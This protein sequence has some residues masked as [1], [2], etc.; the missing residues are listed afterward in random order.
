VPRIGVVHPRVEIDLSAGD[1]PE[2]LQRRL[3]LDQIR[4][5]DVH[6]L[7][8]VITVHEEDVADAEVGIDLREA[9]EPGIPPPVPVM[10]A[11]RGLLDGDPEPERGIR[12]VRG[13]STWGDLRLELGTSDYPTTR[14]IASFI[15]FGYRCR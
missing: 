11:A 10:G 15:T 8:G 3:A 9:R 2:I 7:S 14:L 4:I 6:H 1:E 12:L 13:Q 5:D